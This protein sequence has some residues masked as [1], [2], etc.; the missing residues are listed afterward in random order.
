MSL[1]WWNTLRQ[2]YILYTNTA[3]TEN[4][5]LVDMTTTCDGQAQ[6]DYFPVMNECV[7]GTENLNPLMQ[8]NVL[9]ADNTGEGVLKG[10]ELAVQHFI[11]DT[12]FGFA[13]NVS[14]LDTDSEQN[15]GCISCGFALPGFGNAANFSIFYMSL[16]QI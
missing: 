10:L 3:W 4:P 16:I 13:A 15:P 8:F 6:P 2:L 5:F 1:D 7:V 9:T 14:I 11:G 12:D